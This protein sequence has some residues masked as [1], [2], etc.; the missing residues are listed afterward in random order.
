MPPQVLPYGVS[1]GAG[2]AA[3]YHSQLAQAVS[4]RLVQE[5]LELK[6]RFLYSLSTK[7]YLGAFEYRAQINA[8]TG[9]RR[10]RL[11]VDQR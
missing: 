4:Y 6:Q 11:T 2:A 1:Q 9:R 10:L 3:V 5:L 8:Y 7:V